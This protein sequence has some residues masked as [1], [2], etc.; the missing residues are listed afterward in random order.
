MKLVT[1]DQW[2]ANFWTSHL[3]TSDS[4]ASS[5]IIVLVSLVLILVFAVYSVVTCCCCDT[6]DRDYVDSVDTAN[7]KREKRKMKYRD[8][9]KKARPETALNNICFDRDEPDLSAVFEYRFMLQKKRIDLQ[10]RKKSRK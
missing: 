9:K 7:R 8:V 6:D 4:F 1:N 10:R 2:R 5:T 3:T